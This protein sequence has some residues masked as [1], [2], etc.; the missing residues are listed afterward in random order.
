M[1]RKFTEPS[2]FYLLVIENTIHIQT[3]E[4]LD[5]NGLLY[6]YQSDFCASFSTDSY[7]FYF[8]RNGQNILHWND[9]SCPT[10]TIRHRTFITVEMFWF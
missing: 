5:K 4:Y 8:E 7:G 10:K 6:R 2:H 3:Q 9:S 1:T